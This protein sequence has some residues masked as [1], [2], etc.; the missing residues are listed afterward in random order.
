MLAASSTPGLTVLRLILS[1]H[2][3]VGS[4][5][6]IW[7]SLV[8][9]RC[10]WGLREGI[11]SMSRGRKKEPTFARTRSSES[12]VR[13]DSKQWGF[14]A[15]STPLSLRMKKT[16]SSHQ[17]FFLTKQCCWQI[18]QHAAQCQAFSICWADNWRNS[19]GQRKEYRYSWFPSGVGHIEKHSA[20]LH[21]VV[22]VHHKQCSQHG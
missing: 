11:S 9:W 4:G 15:D 5:M 7:I 13:S 3:V 14:S 2:S 21:V 18:S 20:W 8:E 1:T 22:H 17:P 6:G 16:A 19:C 12:G 10:T